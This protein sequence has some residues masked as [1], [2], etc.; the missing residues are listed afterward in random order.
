MAAAKRR[1][2]EPARPVDQPA[3]ALLGRYLVDGSYTDCFAAA[4]SGD[5]EHAE[6]VAAFY[7]T[8]LFKLERLIL[9]LAAA[10]PSSD[11]EAIELGR[12]TRDHFAAWRVE[13]RSSNQLMLCDFT[14]RTRSW[15]MSVRDLEQ[16]EPSTRLYFG[17]AVVPRID[18]VTGKASMGTGFRLLLGF[19]KLY[20]RLLLRA[21][22]AR[23][24]NY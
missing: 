16:K 5:V 17:S 10:K 15:L 8:W 22:C 19:H 13:D 4:V 21:A 18:P 7:T 1:V 14:G 24:K 6:F 9:K 2:L 12:G 23:L 20:S 3:D 11:E